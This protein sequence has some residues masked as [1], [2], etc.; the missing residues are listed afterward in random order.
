MPKLAYHALVFMIRGLRSK[1][2]QAVAFYFVRSAAKSHTL[3]SCIQQVIRAIHEKTEFRVVASV[4]DLATNNRS[5]VRSQG[6]YVYSVNGH[7]IYHLN[8]VPHFIKCLRN[9][10]ME[11][12]I[13]YDG[14][15]AKWS[16]IR[17]L[18]LMALRR[19]PKSPNCR[20]NI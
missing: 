15:R 6:E 5:A 4:S 17:N 8:N 19:T 20:L 13:L 12:D 18:N 14:R 1:W 9:N 11:K 16:D 2:K 3:K 10:F 7:T